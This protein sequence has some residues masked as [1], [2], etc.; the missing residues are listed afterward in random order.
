MWGKVSCQ[1]KQH[2]G[3]DWASNQRPSDLTVLTS[4]PPRPQHPLGRGKGKYLVHGKQFGNFKI[5]HLQLKKCSKHYN[6][7]IS[8]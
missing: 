7:L 1:R 4:T 6:T 8:K 2:D 3:R 5:Y